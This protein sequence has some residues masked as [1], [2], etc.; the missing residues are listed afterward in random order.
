MRSAWKVRVAGWIAPGRACTTPATISA[1]AP[2]VR[3]R[4]FAAGGHD[5]TGD[6]TGVAFL[7]E[8]LDDRCQVSFGRR[9]QEIGRRRPVAAHAHVERTIVAK[10]EATVGLIELQRGNSEVED[11]AVNGVVPAI[12]R[13][14]LQIGEFVLD[15]SRA[16]RQPR[17][18]GR[19]RARSRCGRG[20]CR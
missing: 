16:A 20:R 6:G 19:L 8:R 9:C 11:D 17:A 18:R 15:Q 7:A 3:D 12:A 1:S 13:D 10:G 14:R 2:V 4:L 5:R